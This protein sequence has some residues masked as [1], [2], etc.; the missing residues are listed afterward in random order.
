MGAFAGTAGALGVSSI[1]AANPL[2]GVISLSALAHAHQTWKGS[3]AEFGWDAIKGATP[4]TAF[5]VTA[6]VV[7]IPIWLG[8]VA[9]AAVSICTS[10]WRESLVMPDAINQAAASLVKKADQVQAAVKTQVVRSIFRSERI[11]Q[12]GVRQRYGC[13]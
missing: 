7:G 10:C 1:A 9:G 4:T 5:V 3:Q 8:A 12:R 13:E 2:L 6:D 11:R